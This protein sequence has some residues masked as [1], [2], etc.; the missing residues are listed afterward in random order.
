MKPK[1]LTQSL[2]KG[3]PSPVYFFS[4]PEMQIKNKAIGEVVNVIPEGQRDFNFDAYYDSE[5]SIGDVLGTARTLPFLAP[6]RVVL[7]K[8]LKKG[9]LPKE[10]EG[11]LTAYLDDPSPQTTLIL[12]T[13]D[14][15]VARAWKR[16][17]G[18]RWT[19][20]EFRTLRGPALRSAVREAARERGVR[21]TAEAIEV[22]VEAVGEDLGRIHGEMEK[23]AVSVGKG[24]EID[25]PRVHLLV[26]GYS[27]QTMFDLVEAVGTRNVGEGLSL[28]SRLVVSPG[29]APALVGMLAKRFR[30]LW[31]LAGAPGGRGEAPPSAFRV[32]KWKIPDLRRQAA[33]F[34]RGEIEEALADLLTIDATV[35]SSSVPFP[36]LME[37]F[38]LSLGDTASVARSRR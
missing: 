14:T 23:L 31:F 26:C 24:E 12:T 38:L 34:T 16:K 29:E 2:K 30:V 35:K 11:A 33:R 1:E 15:D 3:P 7:L 21:I 5:A 19:E 32:L 28:L 25:A 36:I 6:R 13:A 10:K 17:F 8:D 9:K 18:T 37:R 4:G 27:Y 22:L 20:V